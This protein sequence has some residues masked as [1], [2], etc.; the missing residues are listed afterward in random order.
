MDLI[1][2]PAFR[3]AV[4]PP[5]TT[6]LAPVTKDESWLKKNAIGFAN[7]IGSAILLI[8]FSYDFVNEWA[9]SHTG[10]FMDIKDSSNN[11]KKTH[12][13]ESSRQEMMIMIFRLKIF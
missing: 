6:K 5:S 13:S 7:S 4:L 12:G 8:I 11:L 10:C 2:C 1:Q 3:S 9:K